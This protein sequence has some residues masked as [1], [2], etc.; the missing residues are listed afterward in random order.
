MTGIYDD[1]NNVSNLQDVATAL[2]QYAEKISGSSA[3]WQTEQWILRP[4]NFV[5][6]RI[7]P[8]DRSIRISLRG[9]PKEFLDLDEVKVKANMGGGAYS[10]FKLTSRD[11]LAAAAMHI[12][13]AYDNWQ[14]GSKRRR[15]KPVI[16]FV[17]W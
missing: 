8:R 16:S 11:Q 4:K 9:H 17:P 7:Q 13:Q 12:R 3:K 15:Q 10:I 6:F 5:T 14:R 1:L 2:V